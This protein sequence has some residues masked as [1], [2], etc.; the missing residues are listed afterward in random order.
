VNQAFQARMNALTLSSRTQGR[1]KIGSFQFLHELAW[2]DGEASL[3][4]RDVAA[5]YFF[6]TDA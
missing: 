4:K 5:D 2:K 3:S 1:C 6:G